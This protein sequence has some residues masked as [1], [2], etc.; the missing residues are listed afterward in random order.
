MPPQQPQDPSLTVSDVRPDFKERALGVLGGILSG[1]AGQAPGESSLDR[2]IAKHHQMRLDEARMH[3]QNAATYAGVLATGF[4]PKTGVKLTPEEEQQYQNW[5]DASW[6]AYEKAAGISK[7]TKGA[8][9]KSKAIADRIIHLGRQNRQGGAQ[10]ASGVGAS[11]PGGG[12]VGGGPDQATLTEG[13]RAPQRAAGLPPP[14]TMA[15]QTSAQINQA[16]MAAPTIREQMAD[17]QD[18]KTVSG[19][20]RADRLET[21]QRVE[22]AQ[23]VGMDPRSRDYQEF[24]TTGKFPTASRLQKMT[25]IDP[26]D[27]TGTP[28]E[29]SFD[30]NSGQIFDQEQQIVPDAKPASAAMLRPKMFTYQG[31]SGEP[32]I[33]MQQGTKF[34]DQEGNVLP[35]GTLMYVR[36][37]VPTET[38]AQRLNYD[39]QGNP[40]INTFETI[41]GPAYAL[42]KLPRPGAGG[43]GAGAGAGAGAGG[44]ARRG[45]GLPPPPTAG[46]GM[47]PQAGRD[48]LGRPLGFSAA[49]QKNQSQK[50]TTLKEGIR[51]I[52]GDPGNP[53]LQSLN[54]F[55]D[56]ADD[57]KSRERL[58]RAW[59]LIVDSTGLAE[60]EKTHGATLTLIQAYFNVPQRISAAYARVRQDV[61][62]ELTPRELEALDAEITAYSSVVGA[63]ALTSASSA[64]F[65]VKALE[66]DVPIIGNTAT[67]SGQ[68]RDKLTRL[69]EL[70]NIG[71]DSVSDQMIPREEKE[72]YRSQMGIVTGGKKA[73][74]AK[75]EAPARKGGLPPPPTAKKKY[76]STDE[77]IEDLANQVAVPAGK[78]R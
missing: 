27:P 49:Q 56:L 77:E 4:N 74:P 6:A 53:S 40:I 67:S 15:Q 11:A 66:R 52:F 9:Q 75:T 42:G 36:G 44:G 26:R 68:F 2:A 25:Y 39:P 3:R 18:P 21:D 19:K 78:P 76:K 37:A 32:L 13:E 20:L 57:P 65:S 10:G 54:R 47:T 48:A 59:N 69:G 14:P 8:L 45:G 30:P 38:L 33:G 60:E 24:V 72:F 51:Q 71:L 62:K 34:L 1:G 23:K 35:P 31:P 63:R 58:G 70:Y 22:L 46:G 41:R 43:G 28:R 7:E 16:A 73:A 29:G 61:Q 12:A 5:Y 55:S 64:M 50:A 17:L